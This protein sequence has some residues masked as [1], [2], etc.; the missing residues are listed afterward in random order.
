MSTK[1]A[2]KNVWKVERLYSSIVTHVNKIAYT[3]RI[4]NNKKRAEMIEIVT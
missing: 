1:I 4:S 3:H 2:K